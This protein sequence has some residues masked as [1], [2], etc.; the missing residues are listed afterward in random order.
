MNLLIVD[1]EKLTREGLLET[2]DFKRLGIDR[3]ETA[4]DGM[5]G[6]SLCKSFRPDIVL[7][8]VRMPKMDGIRMMEVIQENLPDCAVI[9]MSGFSDKEY[10]KAAIKLRAVSYVEKPIDTEELTEALSDALKQVKERKSSKL[11]IEA[12]ASHSDFSLAYRLLKQQ[13]KGPE[14]IKADSFSFDVKEYNNCFS[15]IIRCY[16]PS[17]SFTEEDA[18]KLSG[19][20]EPVVKQNK[21][22]KL[23]TVN[24][25]LFVFHFFSKDGLNEGRVRYFGD[26]LLEKLG[27]A[28]DGFH[29]VIGRQVKGFKELSHSYNTAVINLQQCFFMEKNTCVLYRHI[30]G[31][32]EFKSLNES[33]RFN[34]FKALLLGE[35]REGVRGFLKDIL[36]ELTGNDYILPN[37]AREFYYRLFNIIIES[38]TEFKLPR[39]KYLPGADLW[40][41]VAACNSVFELDDMLTE[42]TGLFFEGLK[43]SRSESAV[44]YSIKSYI[45]ENYTNMDLSIM[46]VSDHVKLS[47]SY[48]CTLFKSETGITLNQYITEYRLSRARELLSDPRNRIV[49][50]AERVGYSDS[51]YFSKIFRKSFGLSPS[52]YRESL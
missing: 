30:S 46:A 40:E 5:A 20:I 42:C 51:N 52:E 12:S 50:I 39:E 17:I 19:L 44:V 25:P 18:G 31:K 48:V 6:L 7:T 14:E 35:N 4:E 37:Q 27:S 33:E 8:D 21:L 49:E 3:T 45:S 9:F 36:S 28:Y 38:G 10:L 24:N 2:I 26:C 22:K 47:S 29:V 43:S 32:T 11:G 1:D 23:Y 41:Q 13:E 15:V 16:D 34:S